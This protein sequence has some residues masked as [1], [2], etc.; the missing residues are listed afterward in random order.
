[1]VLWWVNFERGPPGDPLVRRAVASA[2]DR[3]GI[4][5]LVA[6]A[7]AGTFAELLLPEVMASCP[8]LSAPGYDP[9][10]AR[11]LLAQAGYADS[12]GDGILDK[13]GEPL[14]IIIGGYPPAVPAADNGRGRPGDAG[15]RGH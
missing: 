13:E 12:D 14:E 8:G 6:P 5:G 4:A 10:E 2:I 15:R 11:R 1:M 3:E 7:G 9:D